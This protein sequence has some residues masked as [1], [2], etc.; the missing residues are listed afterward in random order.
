MDADPLA[1]IRS[2]LRHAARIVRRNG[3]HQRQYVDGDQHDTGTPYDRC[4]VC[5]LGAVNLAV[6]GSPSPD[7][8]RE[9]L[10][11]VNRHLYAYAFTVLGEV[12]VPVWNDQPGRTAWQVALFLRRAAAWT[13][14]VA[15]LALAA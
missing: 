14:P 8:F 3:L 10:C 11:A 15:V 7:H 12:L 13:P 5:T 6:T 9:D 2:H 1:E 4:R